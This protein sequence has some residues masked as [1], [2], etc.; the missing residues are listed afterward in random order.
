MTRSSV[1]PAQYLVVG[2]SH[3]SSV[4]SLRGR[5]LVEEA[6]LPRFL[7]ELQSRGLA[8]VAVLST[9][10][11]I[12]VV[13]AADDPAGATETIRRAL[14]EQAGLDPG[15]LQGQLHAFRGDEAV[16][17]LFAAA[18]GLDAL[19]PGDPEVA[20]H[21]RGALDLARQGGTLGTALE[22][23]IEAALEAAERV[24]AETDLAA[25]PASIAAA[26]ARIARDVHGDLAR[27]AALVIGPGDMG[28]RLAQRLREAGLSRLVLTG[29]SATRLEQAARRL[30]CEIVP[31]DL[32]E[33]A[34]VDADLVIANMGSS[35]PA[36]TAAMV[37]AALKK[38][39][40]R[41]I[42]LVDAAIPGDIER[43]AGEVEEAFLYDLDDLEKVVMA[44][45]AERERAAAAAAE[46]VAGAASRFIGEVG[47]AGEAGIGLLGR[48]F[49]SA[50]AAVLE[51]TNDAAAATRLL[52]DRLLPQVAALV[53]EAGRRAGPAARRDEPPSA[54]PGA[55]GK[56]DRTP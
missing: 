3:R 26:A 11:R 9:P 55:P 13:A 8:E 42:F 37:R 4:L 52:V 6:A 19:V 54:P 16:R 1:P 32:L 56:K 38:R 24:A 28:E 50:R 53:R 30:R 14:A 40:Q 35:P 34:L 23:L 18:A 33:A 31:L 27:A 45:G 20:A 43:A 47:E 10:E 7:G 49:E 44:A 22:S 39:R 21:L 41:P 2:A 25:R 17:H 46:I 12:E 36:I 15:A 48:R 51:E 5:L 29:R